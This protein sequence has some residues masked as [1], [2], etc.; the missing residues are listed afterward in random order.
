MSKIMGGLVFVCAETHGKAAWRGEQA[1]TA[2]QSNFL[3][4]QMQ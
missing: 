3:L 4:R 1:L 2:G